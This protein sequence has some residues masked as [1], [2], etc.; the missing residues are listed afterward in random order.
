MLLLGALVV[1]TRLLTAVSSGSGDAGPSLVHLSLIPGADR[2]AVQ[3]SYSTPKNQRSSSCSQVTY[4]PSTQSL[5]SD[6]SN[7]KHIARNQTA[8]GRWVS[9]GKAADD[10]HHVELWDLEPRIEYSYVCGCAGGSRDGRDASRRS[11][12]HIFVSPA[13]PGR[14]EDAESAWSMLALAD[15]GSYVSSKA[16]LQLMNEDR[17]AKFEHVLVRDDPSAPSI[18][19]ARSSSP[20][21]LYAWGLDVRV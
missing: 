16:T 10:T 4:W 14:A 19:C 12:V 13:A 11:S 3:V 17:S 20:K 5:A 18:L 7:R 1:G 21:P 2:P 9:Y 8:F 6:G 15:H